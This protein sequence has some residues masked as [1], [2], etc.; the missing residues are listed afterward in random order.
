M[1][2][3]HGARGHRAASIIMSGRVV[4]YGVAV[5]VTHTTN[6]RYRS[7][8]FGFVILINQIIRYSQLAQESYNKGQQTTPKPTCTITHVTLQSR[9]CRLPCTLTLPASFHTSTYIFSPASLHSPHTIFLHILML[10]LYV[11]TAAAGMIG[12]ILLWRQRTAR[13]PNGCPLR[14]HHCIR[15]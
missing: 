4:L 15:E 14:L 5:Q 11:A 1:C 10:N 7:Y 9:A 3:C 8:T 2:A 13:A 12:A 6:A